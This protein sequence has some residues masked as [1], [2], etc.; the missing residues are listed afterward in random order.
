MVSVRAL[1]IVV[2]GEGTA[3]WITSVPIEVLDSNMKIPHQKG[4]AMWGH[5]WGIGIE[6]VGTAGMIA[7]S[8]D[9]NAFRATTCAGMRIPHSSE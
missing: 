9:A 2:L 1:A 4:L 6:M 8:T 3:T 7:G 5:A